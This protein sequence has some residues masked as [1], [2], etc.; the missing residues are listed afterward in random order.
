MADLIES[1]DEFARLAPQWNELLHASGAD[2]PFLTH[3]WLETWW[4]HFGGSRR[5]Q[6]LAVRDNDELIALAPLFLAPGPAGMFSRLEFLGTGHAGSDYLDLIVR[7]GREPESLQALATAMKAR[8]R[9]LRLTHLPAA[10]VA[11]RLAD[12]LAEDG[13]TLRTA[14]GGICPVV[15][16]NGHSWDSYL[17]SLGASHRANFRRRYKA[18]TQR[19]DLRFAAVTDEDAR[20]EALTTLMDLHGRRFGK[21]STA[22]V[23]PALREF[24]H[25]ATGR[26]L[27]GGW[28]RMYVL[29]LAGAP[30]AVMYGFFYNNRFYFYQHGFDPQY[31]PFSVGLVLMGL[32]LRAAIEE[33]ALEFDMLFGTERYKALWADDRRP[34]A[35]LQLFPP[36]LGGLLQ[37]RTVEAERAMRT[38]ARRL[39]SLGGAR[40]T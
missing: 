6:L 15:H 18:L 20:H 11:S 36:H 26:A 2:C 31:E 29:R 8:K 38:L 32:T 40:A 28:L 21:R 27:A 5:L 1:F 12:S 4:K 34:L 9:A 19:F 10:S 30:A 17:G 16:L 22:F 35:Q 3:E 14:D 13:W 7:R 39:L 24:H 37:R 23:T 33:G 25:E